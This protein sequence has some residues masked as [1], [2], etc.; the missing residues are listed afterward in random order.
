MRPIIAIPGIILLITRAYRR[1][2]LT[3][4]ALLAA[5]LTASVHAL[6]PSSIPF[7]LLG[8]FFLIGTAATKVKHDVKATLTLSSSGH[9]GGEGPRTSIQVFAN[10]AA[11]SVLVLVHIWLYGLDQEVS[12]FS[13][14]KA[15]GRSGKT[16][17]LL[18][19]GIMAN[20]AAVAADTLSSELGILSKSKPILITNLKPVPPGTNGGVSAAGLVAGIGGGAAIAA[21]SCLLLNFCEANSTAYLK[22]FLLLTALGTADTLLDSL[23]GAALQASVIDRRSGKIVEGPGGVKVLTKPR[24][25]SQSQVAGE[26][27]QGEP[28]NHESRVIS[29]GNDILDNNQINLLMASIVTGAGVLAGT[30]L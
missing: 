17:D 18:L 28:L 12:C 20:Y 13:M 9:A 14:G 5:A 15:S 27:R 11:A 26:K 2:S 4:A 8:T 22:M 30:L 10:S 6:H 21:T 25:N 19:L 16:A 3:P 29:S 24:Q 7:T 1:K 23:L